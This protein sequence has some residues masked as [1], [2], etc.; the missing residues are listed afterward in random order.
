MKIFTSYEVKKLDDE[1]L[2]EYAQNVGLR[3]RR[4]KHRFV[5][6]L[7]EIS[8]RGIHKSHGFATII[9]FAAKV[10][11]IGKKTV[12]AV[13]QLERHV[14]DKPAL[15]NLVG[16]V[17]VHKVRAIATIATKENQAELAKKVES[18]SKSALEMFA[19]EI[20]K[21]E[22]E[23]DPGGN[24]STDV[25]VQ[26]AICQFPPG[27]SSGRSRE[28]LSFSVDEDVALELRKLKMK[29]EK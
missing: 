7:P 2:Y 19:R 1:S 27:R 10:G 21:G 15:K 12:E 3:A 24:A 6:L 29:I 28:H 4:W 9:E 14:I 23:R 20:K 8:R 11:G 18:M 5:A 26:N 25:G 22:S 13:F 17:G 16:K